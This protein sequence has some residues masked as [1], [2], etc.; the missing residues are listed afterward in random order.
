MLT[1]DII[2]ALVNALTISRL[3][4]C[5]SI[6]VGVYDIFVAAARCTQRRGARLI[7][8]RLK[9]DSNSSTICDVL[10]YLPIGNTLSVKL[11]AYV[12]NS[13]RNLVPSYLMDI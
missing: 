10:H 2:I 6:L 5:N 9:F 11:S 3:D 8:Q 1:F 12:F 13:L 7:A 4:Y